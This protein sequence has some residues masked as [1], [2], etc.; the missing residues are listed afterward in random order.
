[1]N[2]SI[3]PGLDSNGSVPSHNKFVFGFFARSASLDG[4]GLSLGHYVDG[5]V[6]GAQIGYLGAASGARM[7]GVQL[8]G[9]ASYT[10][11]E[12]QGG[13]IAGV[14]SW[15]RGPLDGFQLS[16]VASGAAGGKGAQIAG[17]ASVS[18]GSFRGLQL[19]GVANA[20]REARGL[21]LSGVFNGA[22]TMDGLQLSVVNVGGDVRGA[23]I[24]VVN[25]GRRVRGFQLAVVNVADDVDGASVGLINVVKNGIHEVELS[26]TDVGASV[27]SAVLGNRWFYGRLGAGVLPAGNDIPG[28]R[29]GGTAADRGHYLIQWGFGGRLALAEPWFVDIEA[30]GA[31]YHRM[32]LSSF[33]DE[34]AVTGT[35]RALFG[36]RL[37]KNFAV[38]AG[39]S[40][41]ASVGWSTTDLVTG[42][43][44]LSQ[45][46]RSG[47]TT[48][49]L[50]PG[51]V[52]GLRI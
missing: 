45:V 15:A 22:Q 29:T 11:G 1:V 48:V 38:V 5:D 39:P 52:L 16:G 6:H 23:Q 12:V 49:R 10:K 31:N 42:R 9:I 35:A 3:Y 46:Y 41:T 25:V 40:Y 30:V 33:D 26:T 14:A 27:V 17:V 24:G 19:S 21:Q 43:D 37:A 2:F 13:Q 34:D 50:F 32:G 47:E 18:D 51:L 20:A 8:G 28:A 36:Y 7:K 44:F 4:V